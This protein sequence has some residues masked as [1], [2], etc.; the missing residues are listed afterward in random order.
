MAKFTLHYCIRTYYTILVWNTRVCVCNRV[1]IW[2]SRT[3]YCAMPP[4]CIIMSF[5]FFL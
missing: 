2:I 3:S 5:I 4:L 1:R